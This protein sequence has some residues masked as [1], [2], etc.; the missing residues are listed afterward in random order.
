VANL[1]KPKMS[2]LFLLFSYTKLKGGKVLSGAGVST[3][4]REEEVGKGCRWVNV[5]QILC[6]QVCK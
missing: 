1:N 6:T 5:V 4:G 3:S 2:F